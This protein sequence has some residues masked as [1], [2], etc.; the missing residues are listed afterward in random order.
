MTQGYFTFV[1]H[2]HIPWVLGHG[3]WPHGTD[4]LNEA[5]AECY[6]PILEQLY[7]LVDKGHHPQLTIGI[8]PILQEQ[9]RSRHFVTEFEYYLTHK[10]EAARKDMRE[11]SRTG[12]KDLMRVAQMWFAYYS[13]IKML[14]QKRFK[15]DLVAAFRNLQNRNYVEVI[16]SAATHGY[17]PL[18]KH[19]RSLNAQIELG[20]R[21][22]QKNFGRPPRGVW[23]PEC[24]YRP[25][26]KW[27]APVGHDH[28]AFQRKGVD[29]FL[30]K[31][32][33]K[34]FVIDAHL[35]RGGKAI[36]VYLARFK[37]LKNLWKQYQKAIIRAK[38]DYHK[39][40]QEVY[41]VASNPNT[42]PVA[43]L[44][45]DSKTALQVWS[46]DVGYPGEAYYL[47]FHK[48][49]FPSGMRYWRVTNPKIDLA[50]K[51]VYE[52]SHV[53]QKI[54][55]HAHHFVSLVKEIARAYY[56]KHK[57]CAYICTPFD[58]ELFGHWWF[59]GPR[60]LSYVL[61]YTEQ[62]KDIE[63]ATGSA[64]VEHADPDRIITLPEGSWGEGGYHYIWLNQWT[65]WTWQRL[66][67]AEDTF[68]ALYDQHK[69][70]RSNTKIAA[71]QQLSREL[72]LLQ[73]SDWQFLISTWSARDYAE[74]RFSEHYENF[75]KL[76]SIVK[77]RRIGWKD[78]LFLADLEEQDSCFPDVPLSLFK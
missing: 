64:I 62:E 53:E 9:L 14:F 28:T 51:E 16:T 18:L 40:P 75:R 45:R 22:Y 52:P 44:T 76:A 46:G 15:K 17:L 72:L 49:R 78:R 7:M 43:L 70:S 27:K 61:Q 25:P 11:F 67:E 50:L 35:L 66:Y 55:E 20:V 32:H 77:K 57:T 5:A 37:A 24:A 47:D 8:T 12:E 1:L 33:L 56:K 21:V 30:S 38:K 6:I 58:T 42:E 48:K 73:A 65:E 63:L 19:D 36:G 2:S 54:K 29:E 10:I 34:Y 39:R 68:Y 31:N 13:R 69:H 71:L 74:H 60:W 41:L 26:Y 59:E 3:R 4:W 23:L